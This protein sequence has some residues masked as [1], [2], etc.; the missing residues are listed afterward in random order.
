MRAQVEALCAWCGP[1]Q[2]ATSELRCE[3]AAQAEV[4]LCEFSCPSCARLIVCQAPADAVRA[5]RRAGAGKISGCVPFELLEP[6]RGP[7]ISWDD[8][9]DFHVLLEH[10]ASSEQLSERGAAAG[11]FGN[12]GAR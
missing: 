2:V 6:H 10:A 11:R 4:G 9:L 12:G 8:L 3:V 7:V 1:V 5:M